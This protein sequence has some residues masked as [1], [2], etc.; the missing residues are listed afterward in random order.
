MVLATK[1]KTDNFLLVKL[2]HWKSG[3]SSTYD[4]FYGSQYNGLLQC[5]S[6]LLV[7]ILCQFNTARAFQTY[8]FR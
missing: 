4:A 2:A 8:F 1:P 7:P 3:T 6:E 5:L